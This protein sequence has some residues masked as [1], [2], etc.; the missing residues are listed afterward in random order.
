M[1]P[2]YP[3]TYNYR[4]PLTPMLRPGYLVTWYADDPSGESHLGI[5][6]AV[7][8]T[9]ILREHE[10]WVTMLSPAGSGIKVFVHQISCVHAVLHDPAILSRARDGVS[11]SC[12]NDES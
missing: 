2:Y 7:H 9:D 3:Y 4:P 8:F 11:S 5:I 1:P 10:H 12:K 6:L